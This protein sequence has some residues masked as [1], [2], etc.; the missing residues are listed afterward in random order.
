M[1]DIREKEGETGD[2][3]RKFDEIFDAKLTKQIPHYRAYEEAEQEFCEKYKPTMYANYEA[4]RKAR[5]RRI[6]KR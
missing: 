5:A 6:K 3:K 4:Y 2:L 1:T